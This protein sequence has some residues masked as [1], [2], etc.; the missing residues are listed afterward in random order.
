MLVPFRQ[1]A[2]ISWTQHSGPY[3]RESGFGG[4]LIL[5]LDGLPPEDRDESHRVLLEA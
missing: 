1:D 5:R 2:D 4:A 3:S